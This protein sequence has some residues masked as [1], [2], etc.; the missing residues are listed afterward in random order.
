MTRPLISVVVDT[1]NHEGYI[2]QAV[3]SVVEQDFPAGEFEILVVDDGSTD[4][5]AEIV[6]K[7]APRVRLI[8]KKN[9][10]QASAFNAAFPELR[11]EIVA[12]LDGDDWWMPGKLR[13]IASAFERQPEVGAVSHAYCRWY[14]EDGRRET[15]GPPE[16]KFFDLSTPAAARAACGAWDYFLPSSLAIR[17]DVM[18]KAIPMPEV[19]VFGA[20]SP[21]AAAAMAWRTMMIPDVLSCYRIHAGNLYGRESQNLAKARRKAEIDQAVYDTLHAMLTEWGIAEACIDALLDPIWVRTSR[22]LLGTDGG[23][24]LR[25]FQTEMKDRNSGVRRTGARELFFKYLVLVPATLLLPPRSFYAAREWY[26]RRNAARSG[27]GST[28]KNAEKANPSSRIIAGA[29]HADRT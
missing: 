10:G 26:S 15:V 29:S 8:A 16:A 9:G 7:F 3:S 19:L 5:T 14:E 24:R 18:A 6:R 28:G 12:L 22:F 20:D 21:I 17:R 11:G 25:T 13:A 23:S 1:Y 2:A 27:E 4:G